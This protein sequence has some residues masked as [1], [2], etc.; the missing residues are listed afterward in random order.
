M[1]ESSPFMT[2]DKKDGIT[3]IGPKSDIVTALSNKNITL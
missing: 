1:F 2:L 3:L